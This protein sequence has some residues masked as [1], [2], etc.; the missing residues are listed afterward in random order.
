MKRNLLILMLFAV[1]ATTFTACKK[2]EATVAPNVS[3]VNKWYYN[4]VGANTSFSSAKYLEFKA[5]GTYIDTNNLGTGTYT[6]SADNKTVILKVASTGTTLVI[7]KLTGT[8]LNFYFG[9]SNTYFL[10]TTANASM[11]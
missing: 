11:P 4:K 6:I 7:S 2:K 3:I 8:E 10:S 9:D 5:D 1:C